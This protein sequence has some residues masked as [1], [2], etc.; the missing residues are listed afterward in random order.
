MLDVH[1]LR[2]FRAVVASGSVNAAAQ[3][4]GYTASAVS[5]QLTTLQRETGLT[6]FEKSGRGISPTPAALLLAE[7][8]DDV[9]GTLARL[10]GVVAGLREGRTGNL[11]IASFA[12]AAQRWLPHVASV[13]TTEFPEVMLELSLNE[14]WEPHPG[15]RPDID[16]RTERVDAAP[17]QVPG[18]RRHALMDEGYLL[19]AQHEHP[20]FGQFSGPIPLAALAD[21][22]WVDN[23]LNYANVCGRILTDA[24]RAAGFTP[25]Y[26]ARADDHHTALAFVAAG[27]GLTILP[28]LAVSPTLVGLANR[29]LTNPEPRRRIVAQ[30]RNGAETAAPV[31]R[32]LELIRDVSAQSVS[33]G[34]CPEP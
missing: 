26:V 23:D 2:V 12:S 7:E 6:L 20:V 22:P 27:V 21:Y 15:W 10:D 30:V 34:L 17:Q 25:R 5:Q 4:L 8:S 9:M 31:K 16:V 32:A 19:V 18:Y 24:C 29:H 14:M 11:S 13:L 28:A 33:P 1:R 3:H